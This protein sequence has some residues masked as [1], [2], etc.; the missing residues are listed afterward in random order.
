MGSRAARYSLGWCR[1]PTTKSAPSCK[2]RYTS[3]VDT[4][5]CSSFTRP[6]VKEAGVVP[7]QVVNQVTDQNR[8]SSS[9]LIAVDHESLTPLPGNELRKDLR[10]WIAPPDP[11]VNH[12]AASSAHHDGTAEWCT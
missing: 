1:P 11:F 9:N 4:N 10:K 6:D 5:T 2:V 3:L 8:S 7:R 12:N